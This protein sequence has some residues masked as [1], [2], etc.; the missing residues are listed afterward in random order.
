MR[1]GEET[2]I[3]ITPV[4]LVMLTALTVTLVALLSLAGCAGQWETPG[5]LRDAAPAPT[6]SA[7][8]RPYTTN[9]NPR[10]LPAHS[11]TVA[12]TCDGCAPIT[13]QIPA[14]P[15][16]CGAPPHQNPYADLP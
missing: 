12:Q 14:D 9:N 2:K 4:G 16:P 10:C 15:N 5:R 8:P 11:V 6:A 13:I 1:I 3:R 7:T